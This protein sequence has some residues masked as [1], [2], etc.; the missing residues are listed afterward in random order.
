MIIHSLYLNMDAAM[1]GFPCDGWRGKQPSFE[2]YSFYPSTLQGIV[3]EKDLKKL[4][5]GV[6][7]TFLDYGYPNCPL[8][9]FNIF[10]IP[11]L[12]LTSPTHTHTH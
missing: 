12:P 11:V 9:I 4:I 6:N 1:C 10:I 5:E 8:G 7:T 3:E 2:E